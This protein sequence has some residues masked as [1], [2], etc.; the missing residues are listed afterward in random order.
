MGGYVIGYGSTESFIIQL[1]RNRL[2][3]LL[4]FS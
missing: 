2:F 4:L 1:I 3:G